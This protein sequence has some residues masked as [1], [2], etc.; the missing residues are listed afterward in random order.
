MNDTFTLGGDMTV[1]RLGFGAMRVTGKGIWG[2]PADRDAAKAVLRTAVELGIDF[3][4][5]ANA[6]GPETSEYLLAEALHPYD[7][8]VI[9][10]KGG[11]ERPAPNDWRANGEP[12]HLR[13]ACHNSL[14]RL[15]VDQID[16]YQLHCV[17]DRVPLEDSLGELRDMQREGKIRHIG[18]SNFT[19]PELERARAVVDVVSVQNRYNLGDRA[20]E[21]V[22]DYCS[23][24]GIG[25]IPWYPLATGAL[26]DHP[27]L[28]EMAAKYEA[29]PGQLALAWLLARSPT[30]LPIP[31]TSSVAHLEE[32]TGA[33]EISLTAEDFDWLSKASI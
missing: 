12:R 6:Y 9:A 2:W 7:G 8:V 19:V 18:V 20:H 14:R 32:N 10:T 21:P 11:L 4:D 29:S 23:K 15:E 3:I 1:H 28:R 27:H 25:F 5:T 22:V 24:H 33:R 17:D 16:L 31:G 26:A 13:L 30:M